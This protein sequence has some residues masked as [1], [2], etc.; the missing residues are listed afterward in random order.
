[1]SIFPLAAL[2]FGAGGSLIYLF[3]F[4]RRTRQ[5]LHDLIFK[6]CVV[7]HPAP[8]AFELPR[9]WRGHL[10][11]VGVWFALILATLGLMPLMIRS[12]GSFEDMIKTHDTIQ[13]LTGANAV[14][15]SKGERYAGD[16]T[17]HYMTINVNLSKRLRFDDAS[18]QIAAIVAREYPE[19]LNLDY[20]A[21][22]LTYGYDI[23]IASAWESSSDAKPL[24]EWLLRRD[25]AQS[26]RSALPDYSSV[27]GSA[28]AARHRLLKTGT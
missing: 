5:S 15:I 10:V 16:H 25:G 27:A 21:I 24:K 12:S 20:L 8:P 2:V 26:D 9:I 3:L 13:H 19:V 1:V 18:F 23:G 28:A 11:V 6:T 17:D 22:T 14:F 7:R 4:N